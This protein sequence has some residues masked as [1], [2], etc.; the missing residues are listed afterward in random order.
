MTYGEQARVFRMIPGLREA[1]FL[2]FGSVH[3]NTFLN[4][5]ELLDETMQLRAEPGVFVAGQLSG[6]E[7]YVESAAGGFVCSL[8][9][10]QRLFERPLTPPPPPPALGGICTHLARKVDRYQPSNITWAHLPTL[11]DRRLKKR[12]RYE[13]MSERALSDLATW[14]PSAGL[15]ASTFGAKRAEVSA[16]APLQADPV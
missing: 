4:A 16:S 1:E 14:M 11:G 6:V 9:L 8:L 13:A 12:D 10:A 5:P 3:R 7:G 15:P 2:R